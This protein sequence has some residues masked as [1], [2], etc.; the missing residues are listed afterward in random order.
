MMAKTP[1]RKRAFF[2]KKLILRSIY[3]LVLIGVAAFG[4]VYYNKYND[5]KNASPEQLQQTQTD[6][7]ITEI[8]KLYALPTNEKPDVATVKD[9]DALKKQY[10]FFDQAENDDIVLIYKEAKLAILYRPSTKQLIKV[11]PVNVE[12][13]VSIR[14]VGSDTERKAVEKLLTDQQLSFTSGGTAKTSLVGVTVV[15]ISGKKGDEA[16]NLAEVVK[17]KVGGLPEGEEKPENVDLLVLVGPAATA[18]PATT[19]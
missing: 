9:K 10:P 2:S 7:Y 11:G 13:G 19:P 16:K 6:Q 14:V 4:V 18:Q 1:T 5:L 17:G 15:D 12:N 3:V 8:N